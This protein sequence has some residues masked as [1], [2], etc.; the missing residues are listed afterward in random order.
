MSRRYASIVAAEWARS[1]SSVRTAATPSTTTPS[2]S[3]LAALAE[4][5]G[6]DTVGAVLIHGEG[7]SFC[8]GG[9]LAEFRARGD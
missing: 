9:D 2:S 8:A 3:L 7:Q 6:D 1:S 4:L 5:E